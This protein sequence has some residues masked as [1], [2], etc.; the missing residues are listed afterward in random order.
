MTIAHRTRGA[1]LAA[2]VLVTATGAAEAAPLS[3]FNT[4]VDASGTRL[5]DG[6][7]GD[8]HYQLLSVPGGVT[9]LRVRTEVG[10]YP[11]G[12]YFVG[13]TA[14]AWIGP[15]NDAQVDGP[16]GNYTFRTTI[17]LSGFDAASA[18][19]VGQW[20]SDN[21]GLAILINGVD[22]GN[23]ITNNAQYSLGFHDF[24]VSSGFVAGLNT[25]DFVVFN[26]GGPVA[27]RVEMSGTASSLTSVPV[28]AAVLLFGSGLVALATRRRLV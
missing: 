18:S 26:D 27:L 25:L 8:P 24:A 11:I 2:C 7:I 16:G 23:V 3:V 28:P 20:S 13:T 22:T 21:E 10:G 15:N 9:D 17:D 5:A 1:L 6:T 14:S 12:P 19:I 4:G